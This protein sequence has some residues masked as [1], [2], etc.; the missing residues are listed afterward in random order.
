VLRVRSFR[1][2]WLVLG[3]SSLGDWLGL[4][5][6]SLFAAGQVTGSTAKG[7]AF[8]GVVVVRLLPALLLGPVA[9][10]FADRVDRRYLMAACD[11]GRF[12]LFASIP[13]AALVTTGGGTVTW[14]LVATFLI[15]VL[16][17]FWIPAKEAAV[18][19]LVPRGRLEAANQ[20]FLVTTYGIAPVL[21]AGL[22]AGF[23]R[24]ALVLVD[25]DPSRLVV[26]PLDVALYV[27][28]LTFLASAVVVLFFVPEISGRASPAGP[29]PRPPTLL[30]ALRDGWEFVRRT[31]LVRGLVQGILGAFAAG[32]V[33]VGTA[34]F[35]AT[36]LGGGN[37]TFNLLFA[38][39]FVGLS[40]GMA[41]GPRIVKDLSRRR[42]FGMSIV[43]SGA[44][45]A[46]L[47]VVPHLALAIPG[48]VLVGV[49]AGMAFLSG[50]TLLGGEIDDAMR[51]RIFAF[52]QSLVRVVL[53]LAI[54][55]SS[56][57]VG[58]AGSR[59]ASLGPI[60][61]TVSSVRVLFAVAGVL[62][63]ATGVLAFRRMDDRPGVGVLS[64]LVRAVRGRPLAAPVTEARTGSGLF[65]VFEGGEGAGKSTQ[66]VKL[67]A[68]LRVAG[69]RC[70]V[71][72]EPGATELGARIRGLLL[73]P[74]HS[75]MSPRAEALLYAADRAQHVTRTVR[76]A[77]DRGDVVL[78]DR[79]VDSS[80]A[81]QGAGRA[82]PDEE[83][84]WISRWAT[85]GLQP[86]LVVLL[87]VDPRVGLARAGRRGSA[88]RLEQED[89]AFHERV[90][91]GFLA[92]ARLDPERY[93]VL[94]AA[95]DPD[96]IAERVR[97]R[98]LT[99]L[100]PLPAAGEAGGS[101]AG[102][103][104]A[105]PTEVRPDGG[106]QHT[107]QRS[108]GAAEPVGTVPAGTVPAVV[109]G[110]ASGDAATNELPVAGSPALGVSPAD[111]PQPGPA[112]A[113]APPAVAEDGAGVP[114]AS[115][116]T[117]AQGP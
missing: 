37:A 48:V 50:M 35:Y 71:T 25:D 113:G 65:V 54:A 24:T 2:L 86:D 59:R 57:V 93:L 17:L 27:N 115:G 72:R 8:G 107:E 114:T 9:G 43:L 58:A 45:V 10:V 88:D 29:R 99:L 67:A 84:A 91:Q 117:A 46:V 20:L 83:V 3:L 70:V 28:A 77:L 47:A 18:P 94:D 64:D 52:V 90:R 110:D 63:I 21:A 30:R 22:L 85:G 32:G 108:D 6:T 13:L 62:A 98:V 111:R 5:A 104:A 75:G 7:A 38:A 106:V 41:F 60:S 87:D 34:T 69:R 15:E 73:D 112:T 95:D 40:L 55:L 109:A 89:L 36:S 4:L 53:L 103:T 33:V 42:W 74:G 11:V 102:A 16:A 116:A 105:E 39:L 78:S 80:L 61:V 82:L 19:N 79:Y 26:D 96:Q 68:W 81:Y 23:I 14:A 51:G 31:P 97:E 76:P 44:S 92:L 49:G 100:P 66:V 1:R 101:G 12:A 56:L